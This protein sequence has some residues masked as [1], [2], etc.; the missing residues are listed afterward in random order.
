[1]QSAQFKVD[2][3]GCDVFLDFVSRFAVRSSPLR[4]GR[5]CLTFGPSTRRVWRGQDRADVACHEGRGHRGAA[6]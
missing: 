1:M 3:V 5:S 6:S 2:G 4:R